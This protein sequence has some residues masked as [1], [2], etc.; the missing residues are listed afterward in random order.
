[1]GV[2]FIFAN[3]VAYSINVCWVCKAGRHNRCIEISLF[4]LVSG[5]SV[6]IGTSMMG[7]LIKYYGMQTT[8]AF[9][10]NIVSAVMINYGMRKFYIFKG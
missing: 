4:Y 8:Y 9:T 2:A 5:V 6:V 3:M 10:A 7:F 1:N